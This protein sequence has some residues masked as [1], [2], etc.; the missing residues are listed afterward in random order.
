MKSLSLHLP[1]RR[2]FMA[3]AAA[4]LALPVLAQSQ[5]SDKMER[6][7]TRVAGFADAEM[8]YQLMRQLGTARYGGAAVGEC[9]ALAQRIQNGVPASW[10]AEFTAAAQRQE[11]DAQARALRGHAVSARGQ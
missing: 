2:H 7:S 9:L 8:D 11:A 5:P 10:V 4:S 3:A 6:G 1:R